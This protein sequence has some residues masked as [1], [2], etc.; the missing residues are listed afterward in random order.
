M[1]NFFPLSLILLLG[2]FG[3]WYVFDLYSFHKEVAISSPSFSSDGKRILFSMGTSEGFAM[4]MGCLA[5][6]GGDE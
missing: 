1:K 6:L 5:A 2:L 3:G 4:L